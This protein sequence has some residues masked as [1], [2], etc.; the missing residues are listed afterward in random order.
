MIYDVLGIGFGPSNLAL[1]IALEESGA[2]LT[3]LFLEKQEAFGWHTGMLIDDATMQVSVFKDLVTMR[4]P[5][6]SYSY[7][8][9][10]KEKGRLVDFIN[11]KTLFPLRIEFHDYLEWAASRVSDQVAYG[12]EVVSV[13]PVEIDGVVEHYEVTARSGDELVTHRAR[14]LTVALGLEPVLPPGVDSG[15]RVWHNLEVVHRVKAMEGTTPTRFLVV[16]AGQSAAET[17]DY[18]HRSFPTAEVCNVFARYGYT[19]ADDSPFAN[20]IFDPDAVDLYFGAPAE[21]KQS[22][23]DYHRNTNYSVVDMDLI[24]SMYAT[25]YREKVTGERRLNLLNASRLRTV[26]VRDDVVDVDVEFLPTGEVTAYACDAVVYATGYRPA[27]VTRLLGAAAELC[28]RDAEGN[29][30]VGRDYRIITTGVLPAGVYQQGGTEHVHGI[31]STLL[32]NIAIRSGEIVESV[33]AHRDEKAPLEDA[34]A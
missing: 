9:Y 16:G 6:S 30:K 19:P 4:N 15:P 20:T 26:V 25:S 11:H 33:L 34:L 2:P 24:Q 28:E 21:V 29:V 32:S 12:H 22:L 13:Q 27:D 8:H 31:T 18:L 10:L 5:G 7:L 14:N 3:S 17:V 23:W 1:A